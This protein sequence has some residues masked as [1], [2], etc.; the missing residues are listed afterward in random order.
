ML[1]LYQHVDKNK[2]RVLTGDFRF[3]WQVVLANK[4][5]WHGQPNQWFGRFLL[6]GM[7]KAFLKSL[8]WQHFLD[9]FFFYLVRSSLEKKRAFVGFSLHSSHWGVI[10]SGRK[11][12]WAVHAN[13]SKITGWKYE[14]TFGV[15]S[16]CLS[17]ITNSVSTYYLRFIDAN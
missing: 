12:N 2:T 7:Y 11:V 17:D 10:F 5:H 6:F 15:Q 9:H 3:L 14:T 1:F 4:W 16:G 8:V 13:V